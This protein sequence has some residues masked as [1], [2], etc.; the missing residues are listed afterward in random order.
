MKKA[1]VFFLLMTALFFSNSVQA[2]ILRV[3]YSGPAVAGVDYAN[4]QAAVNAAAVDDT[5]QLYQNASVG[6]A[7]VN[8]RLVFV[9]FGYS[10]SSNP[11]LQAT[12]N[13]PNQVTLGFNPGSQ[14]SKVEG[15]YG[16]FYFGI[17][18][19]TISRCL[20]TVY[21]GYNYNTGAV[22]ISSATLISSN[23]TINGDYGQVS[24]VLVSNCIINSGS[25]NN[26]AGLFSNN[27]FMNSANV[28]QFGSCVVK[29]NIFTYSGYGC[30][31]GTSAVFQN[32]LFNAN[33]PSITGSGNQFNINMANVFVNWNNG[34]FG[35]E[36]NIAL[37]AGSP[38]LGAGLDG[39]GNPTDAGIYGGEPGL[40]YKP[41]GI[42]AI[43]A[44]Y[45]LTSPGLNAATNPY[46]ITVSVRS[47]N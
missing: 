4:V 9:G 2:K 34:S 35:S 33:C 18:N 37:K 28:M 23:L 27:I 14:D 38:A 26:V 41:S 7:V 39:N 20:G 8:K 36:S 22:P 47:N 44:V 43:P 21:L 42:P 32:N 24:N 16:N 1:L 3:A 6:T 40:V 12:T 17:N 25:V 46:T 31:S 5:I 10:L 15:V 29:N 45:Q 19:I 11:G 13:A 30:P